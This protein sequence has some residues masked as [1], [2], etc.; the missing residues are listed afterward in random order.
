MGGMEFHYNYLAKCLRGVRIAKKT[1]N[2]V[3][4]C[5]TE[6]SLKQDDF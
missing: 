1:V 6:A 5:L 4:F 2:V 3:M